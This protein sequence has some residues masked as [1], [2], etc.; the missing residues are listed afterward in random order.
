M[1]NGVSRKDRIQRM[2][3]GMCSDSTHIDILRGLAEER[4]NQMSEQEMMEWWELRED[5]SDYWIPMED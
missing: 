2:L 5:C 1:L 4:L 3:D